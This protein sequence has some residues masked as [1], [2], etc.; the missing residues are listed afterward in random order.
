MLPA[1]LALALSACATPLTDR[2]CDEIDR[3]SC[4][5]PLPQGTTLA[6]Y[7]Q[8]ATASRPTPG[9]PVSV[10]NVVVSAIDDFLEPRGST[11]D[12]WVQE[13]I[14]DPSFDGC[15]PMPDGRRVC[16]IQL[17]APTNIPTGSYLLVGDTVR[18]SGGSYDEFDCTPCCPPPRRPCRFEGRTL[19]EFSRA[20]VERIG[21]AVEPVVVPATIRQILDG[22][23]RYVG[24]L[25]RITDE[26]ML[27]TPT[28]S[29]AT[30]GEIRM[31]GGINLTS[32]IGPLQDRMGRPL[33]DSATGRLNYNR[34]RNVTGIVSYF[35]GPKLLP[36]GPRDF[37]V[38]P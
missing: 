4:N 11:G 19:P 29:D 33:F 13:V 14:N 16:G 18:V 23:D 5:Q 10:S 25:V 7:R 2:R 24:V 30:R 3:R 15:A 1:T 6:T 32:Q 17:F 20:G 36:R 37:E 38:V 27:E 35:F 26:V 9:G 28:G 8:A 34:L 31:V 12:V 21:T 22:G